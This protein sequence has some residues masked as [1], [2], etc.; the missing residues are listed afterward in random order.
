FVKAAAEES[1][2]AKAG[3]R[4]HASWVARFCI[5]FYRQALLG[6]SQG[7]TGGAEQPE[8]ARFLTRFPG[9]SLEAVD[10]VV[11]LLE[12]CLI[13][14]RQLEGNASLA[15]CLESLFQDLGRL[16]KPA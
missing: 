6:L 5:E 16:L 11:E 10:L 3:Q 1:S 9:R 2:G 13:A 7:A 8:V 4:S 15:M 14:D 12:R